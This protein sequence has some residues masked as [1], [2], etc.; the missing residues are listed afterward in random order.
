MNAT[1]IINRIE[2]MFHERFETKTMSRLN[3]SQLHTLVK[4]ANNTVSLY[5][6]DMGS[7]TPYRYTT[8]RV[9]LYGDEILIDHAGSMDMMCRS[10]EVTIGHAGS[11]DMMCRSLE[12]DIIKFFDDINIKFT[13]YATCGK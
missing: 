13:T 1:M 8:I 6:F 11:M 12:D 4:E 10:H 9:Q 2:S 7:S 3:G 5:T